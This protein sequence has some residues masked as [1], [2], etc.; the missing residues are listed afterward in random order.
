[1]LIPLLQVGLRCIALTR[2][3]LPLEAPG[4]S[5]D[6]FDDMANGEG[7]SYMCEDCVLMMTWQTVR[8][9]IHVRG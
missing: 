8:A 7:L 6:F 2:A 9:V 5:D 3:S 4:R 1:V